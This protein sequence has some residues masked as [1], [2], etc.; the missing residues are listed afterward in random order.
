VTSE[1]VRILDALRRATERI[2]ELERRERPPVAII[3]MACRF[4]GGADDPDRFWA[5]LRDGVDATREVPPERW[6]VDAFFDPDPAVPGKMYVRRGGFLG[7]VDQFDPGFFGIAPRE[8]DGMDPQQRLLLE[9]SWEAIEDAAIPAQVLRGSR[10][11]VFVGLSWHDYE[12]VACA[13]DPRAVDAYSGMGNTGSI[14]AGRIAYVLGLHGPTMVVDT[15]CSAS[16]TAI[17]QACLSLRV[18]ESDL[19][20]AGGVSLMLSP[21]STIF[22][23]KIR[24]LSP[25]GRSYTFDERADGYA[26]GEGCGMLLLKR[27]ADAERDGDRIQAVIRGSAINH[28]GP[29][30]GLTVPNG[31]AQERLLEAALHDAGLAAALISYVE[32]HGTGTALGDPIE[33]A[34]IAKIYGVGRAPDR[35]LRVGSVKTNIG[36]AEAAAGVA[37]VIKTVLAL[38]NGVIPAHLNFARPNHRID[39]D[40]MNVEVPVQPT[41]WPGGRRL[42]G[43]SSFGFSGTNAHVIVEGWQDAGP[44]EAVPEQAEVFTLSARS[45][46]ALRELS[47]LHAA[48]LRGKGAGAGLRD[49]CFSAS[50]GRTALEQRAAW[51]VKDRGELQAALEEHATAGTVGRGWRGVYRNRR[52]RVAFLFSGQGTQYAGMGRQLYEQE[53]SYREA[54]E[55]C[56]ELVEG[57]LGVKLEDLLYGAEA[58]LLQQTRY[59]QPALFAVQYALGRTWRRWGVE[60]QVVL[61]HSIGEYVAAEA[62]GVFTLAAGLKLVVR[63]GELMEQ[64]CAGGAMLSVHAGQAVVQAALARVTSEELTV[65]VL[66]GPNQVVVSGSAAGVEEL[67]AVLR[68]EGVRS[69]RLAVSHGFHSA[70]VEPMLQAWQAELEQ[71]AMAAPQVTYVSSMT[72]EVAG[73]E[74][75]TARYWREQTRQAVRFEAALQTVLRQRPEVLLEVGAQPALLALARAVIDREGPLCLPSL[76]PGRADRE[77][78]LASLAQLHVKGAPVR[79]EDVRWENL[80]ARAPRPRKLGLPT[81]PFQRQR[82][83]RS[84]DPRVDRQSDQ[85]GEGSAAPGERVWQTELSL[86]RQS[87]LRDHRVHGACVVPATSF[88]ALALSATRETLAHEQLALDTVVVSRPLRLQEGRRRL[89]ETVVSGGDARRFIIRSRDPA[90]AG[91]G[92]WTVHAE[93]AYGPAEPACAQPPEVDLALAGDRGARMTGVELRQAFARRGIAYGPTFC[94]VDEVQPGDNV[95]VGRLDLMALATD[96][97]PSVLHPGV[98]DAALQVV[99]ACGVYRRA[100]GA[101]VPWAFDRVRFGPGARDANRYLVVAEVAATEAIRPEHL[102]ADVVIFDPAGAVA[103][104]VRGLTLRRLGAGDWSGEDRGRGSLVHPVDWTPIADAPGVPDPAGTWLLVGGGGRAIELERR[105]LGAFNQSVQVIRS[106]LRASSAADQRAAIEAAGEALRGVVF[107][108]DPTSS[109]PHEADQLETAVQAVGVAVASLTRSLSEAPISTRFGLW[110]V[111]EGA[112]RIAGDTA[113]PNLAAASVCGLGRTLAIE[114]PDLNVVNLDLPARVDDASAVDLLWNELWRAD[115]QRDVALRSRRF[116]WLTEQSTPSTVSTAGDAWAARLPASGVPFHLAP[117]PQGRLDEIRVVAGQRSAVGPGQVEITVAV[118]GLNFRDV[119]R[120]LR[121][122]SSSGETFGGECS[123]T[124]SAVGEGVAGF[125]MGD[126]VMALAAGALSSHVVVDARCVHPVP[127]DWSLA[128]AATVPVAFLTADLGLSRLAQLRRGQSILIHAAA[129]GV[130]LAAVMIARAK[131]AEIFATASPSKWPLLARLGVVNVMSSRDTDFAAAILAATDGRGVDV[132]LNALTGPAVEASLR[133]LKAGGLFLE[134][135]KTDL[136]DVARVAAVNPTARYQPFDLGILSPA[137]VATSFADLMPRF[138]VGDLVPLPRRIH[139]VTGTPGAFRTMAQAGHL[140][141]IVIAFDATVGPQLAPGASY[142][143]TGGTGALGLQVIG[144]LADHGA[145]HVIVA[146]RR[147]PSA[148]AQLVIDQVRARGVDVRVVGADI[149][150][151]ADVASV[152]EEIARSSAVLRG[153][154][155]TAGALQDGP[156]NGLS[157]ADFAAVLKPKVRGG[158]L[159]HQATARGDLD[160]FVLFSSV[161]SVHGSRGQGNYSA[162]N[163]FLDALAH[164]RS[165]TGLPAVS[166]NWGAWAGAGM[167]E[168]VNEVTRRRWRAEGQGWLSPSEGLAALSKILARFEPQLIAVG[169]APASGAAASTDGARG[170]HAAVSTPPPRAAAPANQP[171]TA[172]R[173]ASLVDAAVR[174]VLALPATTG[175]PLD[176]PLRE[177]GMDSLMAMELRNELGV[178]TGLRLPATVAYDHPHVAGLVKYLRERLLSADRSPRSEP[179]EADRAPVATSANDARPA[180]TVEFFDRELDALEQYLT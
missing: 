21:L 38:R 123:G 156:L 109:D 95:S 29:S 60:P 93:G 86:D 174:K 113:L 31:T 94:A 42:A 54:I 115:R 135:G 162:A 163:A 55:E 151:P 71:V 106:E 102:V 7:P 76:R 128:A 99:G 154:F 121:R 97:S 161:A 70:A 147:P 138:A 140:G 157:A 118:A 144:W 81:Y 177:L 142:L 117:D 74:V 173:I 44:V 178:A 131:G 9:S 57:K 124:I 11:G 73:A 176:V 10:T 8:A 69:E 20:L 164:H 51:V 14:A 126:R 114:Q 141:K 5:L 87:Y 139:P 165:A 172:K 67:A 168:T 33:L 116:A 108:A 92:A 77:Q 65:S 47:G 61:G 130:G 50:A 39:W 105:L 41:S 167:A 166:V 40:T 119:L 36:H 79:W 82:H 150:D 30:S 133:V 15:A 49:V 89:V 125:A 180:E 146:A 27:L 134:M 43:V 46:S 91:D 98:L 22:C 2:E 12:R 171:L 64:L 23:C 104:E 103:L 84:A 78:M 1:Q 28:D 159:L 13:N 85:V 58:E 112:H 3:G 62:A 145:R 88:L 120:G 45:E 52:P 158:W 152:F 136:W 132:V 80:Q 107:F 37:G 32:A 83:W 153:V 63:R 26:R 17:H 129:T 18:G 137:E 148:D 48:W 155:H 35:P 68:A 175:L 66:N 96:G 100:D 19:A 127:D 72:G 59:A 6:D 170:A 53:A 25:S 75:A 169:K 34:A 90:Q 56:G 179:R 110:L 122:L 24:A 111:T 4:P 16:L 143:V 160:L 101:F 149:G